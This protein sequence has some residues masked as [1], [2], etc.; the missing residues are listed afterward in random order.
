MRII[1]KNNNIVVDAK[2]KAFP[3]PQCVESLW[4]RTFVNVATL[5]FLVSPV[6]CL[7]NRLL[8]MLW[9]FFQN[10]RNWHLCPH[11]HTG[12]EWNTNSLEGPSSSTCHTHLSLPAL[13]PIYSP[14]APTYPSGLCCSLMKLTPQLSH[15]VSACIPLPSP[16][17]TPPSDA[18]QGSFAGKPDASQGTL[19]ASLVPT[20]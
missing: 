12:T 1:S 20:F 4:A 15:M 11:I 18:P 14:P 5:T 16:M 6:V 9:V 8:K 19:A 7:F 2:A 17:S 3:V 10:G 13:A